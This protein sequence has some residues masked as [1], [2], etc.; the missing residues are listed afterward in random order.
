MRIDIYFKNNECLYF[1]VFDFHDRGLPHLP[2]GELPDKGLEASPNGQTA[3]AAANGGVLLHRPGPDRSGH[4]QN[5]G[6]QPA[7]LLSALNHWSGGHHSVR[8]H[9]RRRSGHPH[10]AV[11]EGPY[12]GPTQTGPR[13]PRNS[14]VWRRHCR[15]P[16]RLFH[17]LPYQVGDF[18]VASVHG[19]D[20][21]DGG[22]FGVWKCCEGIFQKSKKFNVKL[23]ALESRKHTLGYFNF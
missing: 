6:R 20:H 9:R 2:A 21:A 19:G 3:L 17:L 10:G 1:S 11:Q 5:H 23:K 12:D 15:P 22:G 18:R 4:H 14:G 8:A 7:L 16:A 13:R